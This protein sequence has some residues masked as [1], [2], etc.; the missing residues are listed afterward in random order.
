MSG[1]IFW[2]KTAIVEVHSQCNS[3]KTLCFGI[4]IDN[5][6]FLKITKTTII[7]VE[8]NQTYTINYFQQ[9]ILKFWQEK[10][11][12]GLTFQVAQWCKY[13]LLEIGILKYSIL[14]LDISRDRSTGEACASLQNFLEKNFAFSKGAIFF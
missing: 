8:K 9:W 13:V 4:D 1:T 10:L 6:A 14:Q 3:Q 12:Y 11:I 2:I 7:E 5:D